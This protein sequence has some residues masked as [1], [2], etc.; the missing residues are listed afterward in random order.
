MI[1]AVIHGIIGSFIGYRK[2]ND[3]RYSNYFLLGIT[4]IS[5]LI[6]IVMILLLTRPFVDAMDIV[7]IVIIPMVLINS[8][9]MVI[10]SMCSS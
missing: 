6:H 10:F 3:R 9:G 4:F 5:E 2:R 1:S 7:R 8:V